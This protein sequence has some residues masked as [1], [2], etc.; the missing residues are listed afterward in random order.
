MFKAQKG[1]GVAGSQ[2]TVGIVAGDETRE[3]GRAQVIQGLTY[4]KA[5]DVTVPVM[6]R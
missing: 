2:R 3:E 4:G 5:W 1:G 6:T